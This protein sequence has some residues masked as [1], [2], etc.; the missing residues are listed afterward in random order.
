M[1][2]VFKP[3]KG[4]ALGQEFSGIVDTV[5]SNVTAFKEGDEVFGQ[6]DFKMGA[7]AQYLKLPAKGMIAK[8]PP[9]I[10][11]EEA[12]CVSLG[13]LESWYFLKEAKLKENN[14]ILIIGAGGSIG[15][16]GIQ[17]AKIL[18][19]EVTGVDIGE[20]SETIKKAG[21]DYFIDY[22]KEDYLNSGKTYD[23]ILDVVGKTSLK[24]G[25]AILNEKG[26]YMQANPK[27]YQMLFKGLINPPQGKRIVFKRDEQAK[28]D[29]DELRE[30]LEKGKIKPIIDKV[31]QLEN[32]IEAHKYVEAGKKKGNLVLRVSHD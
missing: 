22:T 17:L 23:A 5:G 30:F 14:R 29:L 27:T 13:G 2:G 24:R 12:A 26:V 8:K 15:T 7:Y 32:V 10:S 1:M 19:A 6:T 20:K 11:F 4:S 28:R 16:M 9:N 21:A 18:G 31:M 3:R 25:L